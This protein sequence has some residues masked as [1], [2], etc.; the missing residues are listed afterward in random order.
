MKILAKD[1]KAIKLN[2]GVILPPSAAGSDVNI[3]YN[4]IDTSFFERNESDGSVTIN[5]PTTANNW[6]FMVQGTGIMADFNTGLAP[7]SDGEYEGGFAMFASFDSNDTEN[8]NGLYSACGDLSQFVESGAGLLHVQIKY[9][10][11]KYQLP[12]VIENAAD[13]YFIWTVTLVNSSV[14]ITW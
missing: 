13:N 5:L 3:Q 6:A 7:A 12:D 11:N 4:V 1:G 2:G 8:E 9:E 10:N 14:L